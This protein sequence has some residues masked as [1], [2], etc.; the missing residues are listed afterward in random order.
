MMTLLTEIAIV[1]ATVAAT[2]VAA[3][4]LLYLLALT[5]LEQHEL[6]T[7]R[8]RNA[9]AGASRGSASLGAAFRARATLRRKHA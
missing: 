8:G 5:P 2:A 4:G 1:A 3:G 7:G 6:R 9:A